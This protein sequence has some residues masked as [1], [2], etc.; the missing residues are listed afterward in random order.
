MRT[1]AEM[2]G[3]SRLTFVAQSQKQGDGRG[4]GRELQVQSGAL[5][6][7]PVLWD[8]I[9]V[10]VEDG[11]RQRAVAVAHHQPGKR[12]EAVTPLMVNLE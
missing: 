8:V 12:I 7:Q 5:A 4:V 1:G 10:R 3:V 9:E 2:T 11:R 6:E